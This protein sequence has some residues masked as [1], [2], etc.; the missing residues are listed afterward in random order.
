MVRVLGQDESD[1]VTYSIQYNCA[2]LATFERYNTEK[3][4]ALRDEHTERYANKF[5]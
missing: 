2:D 3:A 1:G 5:V 4:A